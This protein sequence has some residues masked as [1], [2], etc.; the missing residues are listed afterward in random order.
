MA[1]GQVRSN[2]EPRK[3]KAKGPKKGN[4]SNPSKKPV[5]RAVDAN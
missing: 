1:K 3:P 2:K 5:G 4:A